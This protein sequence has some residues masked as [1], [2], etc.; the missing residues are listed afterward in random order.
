MK[1]HI[2]FS[3]PFF[4]EN[5][6]VYEITWKNIVSG[7]GHAHCVLD[8]QGYKHAISN[9]YCFSTATMVAR[10]QHINVTLI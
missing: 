7:S 8:N 9:T 10:Q 5:L 2:L 1:A 4:V 6:A 3:V